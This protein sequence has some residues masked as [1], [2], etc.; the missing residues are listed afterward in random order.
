M[1]HGYRGLGSLPDTP[2]IDRRWALREKCF[3]ARAEFRIARWGVS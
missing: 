2:K 3:E 1:F